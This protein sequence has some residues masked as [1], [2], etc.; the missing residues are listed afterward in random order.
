M[1]RSGEAEVFETD[2]GRGLVEPSG[3]DRPPAN[4]PSHDSVLGR[5]GRD[6]VEGS[7][8]SLA[9][10]EKF[11][12]CG[13]YFLYRGSF[14]VYVGQALD[15]RRR[16]GSHIYE[17]VK[18]FDSASCMVL[19]PSRL[20]SVEAHFIELFLPEFNR[21]QRSEALR[22]AGVQPIDGR[23]PP[24]TCMPQLMPEAAARFLGV[25]LETLH[26]WRRMGIGP[27]CKRISGGSKAR[28]YLF[29]D[30]RKFAEHQPALI[31]AGVAGPS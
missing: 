30:L 24:E 6:M 4:R 22:Y 29:S 13:V 28:Y 16:I 3:S 8:I 17:A 15:M 23:T 10:L 1:K 5:C 20:L 18:C 12:R 14:V 11:S 9:G 26:S 31:P 19:P 7:T 21:C 27:R 25:D 2:A